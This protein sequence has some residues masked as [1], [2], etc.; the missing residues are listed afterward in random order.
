MLSFGLSHSNLLSRLT[1]HG[2]FSYGIYIYAFPVQQ[3]VSMLRPHA[4]MGFFLA[5]CTTLTLLCGILSWHFVE[6]HALRLK[7]GSLASFRAQ[8][9]P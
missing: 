4:G 8:K 3:T 9:T 2:D 7:P 6:R 5:S 1:Q